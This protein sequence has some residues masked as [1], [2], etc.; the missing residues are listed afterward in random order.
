[1]L[2]Y[3][4]KQPL[5]ISHATVS[6]KQAD[7]FGAHLRIGMGKHLVDGS[8]Q[9]GTFRAWQRMPRTGQPVTWRAV[10]TPPVFACSQLLSD[11]LDQIAVEG[12]FF[13]YGTAHLILS[14]NC[15]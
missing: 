6:I 5:R 1:V 8:G 10:L 4:I 3:K 11:Q 9:M 2:L 7:G 13:E 12:Y 14:Y 15:S